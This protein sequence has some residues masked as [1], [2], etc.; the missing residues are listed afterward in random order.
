SAP[1]PA[2]KPLP[3][4]SP[5]DVLPLADPPGAP[6]DPAPL[7]EP[8]FAPAP[9]SGPLPFEAVEQAASVTATTTPKGPPKGRD[10]HGVATTVEMTG[11]R[12]KLGGKERL[13]SKRV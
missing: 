10:K 2:S 9:A 4:A 8:L 13:M 12:R 1:A 3:P 6:L 7:E 11:G 5:P